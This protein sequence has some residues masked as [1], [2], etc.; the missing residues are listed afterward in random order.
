MSRLLWLLIAVLAVACAE[1]PNKELDQ[2][3]GAIDAA[4]AAG[5]ERYATTEFTAATTALRDAG[6][7]VAQRD[8]RLALN[9]ALEGREQA[10]NA[11]R[12]AAETRARLRGEV[13][14]AMAET[15]ALLSQTRARLADPGRPTRAQRRALA[16]VAETL[17]G[18]EH[19][20]Q[21]AGAAM[22]QE[23]YL[24]VGPRLAEARER[25]AAADAAIERAFARPR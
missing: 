22:K 15:Q 7:A 13:E 10:Q 18:I 25:L 20:L 24:A 17:T 11:A 6:Q 16:T 1:P 21:E 8:Y 5:A 9:L 2:A 4:R 12:V 19:D 14:R 3:Q 23:D